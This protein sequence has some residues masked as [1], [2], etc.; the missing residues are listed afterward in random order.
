MPFAIGCHDDAVTSGVAIEV[1]RRLSSANRNPLLPRVDVHPAPGDLDLPRI[2][3]ICFFDVEILRVGVEPLGGPRDCLVVPFF[4]TGMPR[5]RCTD[6]IPA[7]RVQMDEVSRRRNC[8]VRRQ[9]DLYFGRTADRALDDR[10]R[11]GQEERRRADAPK[12]L[13]HQERN[14]RHLDTRRVDRALFRQEQPRA[15]Q[16]DDGDQPRAKDLVDRIAARQKRIGAIQQVVRRPELRLPA[17]QHEFL[18]RPLARQRHPRVHTADE[19]LGDRFRAGP[20]AFPL[21]VEIATI[22]NPPR[23]RVALDEVGAEDLGQPPL[24]RSPPQVHLKQA[25]LRLREPLRE[26]EIAVVL[27]VDV[28]HAPPVADDTNRGPDTVEHARAR[29]LRHER[30]Q[31]R[32]VP[33]AP[34]QT[35]DTQ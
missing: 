18:G 35:E 7:R 15:R 9:P 16:P 23:H 3:G 10:S 1:D 17:G 29:T 33:P 27:R 30:R 24:H 5:R 31:R 26:E 25:I 2:R 34:S 11:E 21:N 4:H 13:G 22:L 6:H 28:R 14:R 20:I 32:R 19:R 8:R 12:T